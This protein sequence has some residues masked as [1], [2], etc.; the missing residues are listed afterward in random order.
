VAD[1]LSDSVS[2][3]DGIR[4]QRPLEQRSN[5]RGA[6]ASGRSDRPSRG[7]GLTH[8]ARS[9]DRPKPSP[10]LQ[11]SDSAASPV[12]NDVTI[13]SPASATPA[14]VSNSKEASDGRKSAAEETQVQSKPC[15]APS[16]NSTETAE[17]SV[18]P[19][20]VTPAGD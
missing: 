3:A 20:T 12:S 2:S 19:S 13:Q 14:T 1:T 8:D 16:A 17:T 15:M 18:A 10:S 6:P 4:A 7:R 5:T 11:Q 9:N